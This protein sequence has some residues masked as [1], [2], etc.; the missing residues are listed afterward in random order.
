MGLGGSM[1]R[2]FLSHS[3]SDKYYVEYIAEKFGKDIAIYDEYSFESGLNTFSEILKGLDSSDIFVIFLSNASLES[4]WVKKELNISKDLL[5]EEKLKQIYPIIIDK[6]LTYN[7][8]RIPNWMRE[9]NN[10]YVLR[11]IGG[12]KIAYKK[13]KQ[14]LVLLNND[15]NKNYSIYVGHEDLTKK[16]DDRYYVSTTSIK[17]IIACGIEGIGRQSFINHCIKVPKTFNDSYKPIVID[18]NRT[19]SIDVIIS[20]LIESGLW[21]D[22]NLTINIINELSL[23]NKINLLVEI[24][25]EIQ[26]VKEFVIFR[27]SG[28]LIQRQEV[29]WW[30]AKSLE[31]IRNELTIGI[32]T[33]YN[34][35]KSK[36][37][38]DCYIERIDE[39]DETGKLKMLDKLSKINNINL[40]RDDIQFFQNIVTGHPLQILFCIENIKRSSLE[41]V[42]RNS[43]E[44][45]EFLSN[46]T[47]QIIDKYLALLDYKNE[48]KEKFLSY[49]TFLAGYS[50]IPIAEILEIN[51]LDKDYEVFYHDL[52]SFCI[53][54]RTGL[55]NDL[56][57]VSP[58]VVDYIERSGI[59]KPED[60]TKYLQKEYELFK[61]RL[62]ENNLDEYCYSQIE[63]NIKEAIIKEDYSSDYKLI[64]PSII[65][66]AVIKLYDGKSY[67]KVKNVCS[68]CMASI[69]L[70]DP[71][72]RQTLYFYYAMAVARKKENIIFD[73]LD[74]KVYGDYIL[75]E[76]QIDFIKGFYYKLIGRYE[77]AVKHFRWCLEKEHNYARARRELVETYVLLDEFNLALDLARLN[78]NRF[79][80]NI[81]NIYQYFNC[82]I[83]ERIINKEL[84]VE[85]LNKAKYVDRILTNSKQFYVEMQA[86]YKQI[87]EGDCREAINIMQENKKVFDNEVLYYRYLFDLY[88]EIRDIDKMGKTI[89]ILKSLIKDD[90]TYLP[91]LFRRECIYIY[92]KNKDLA[93]V[94]NKIISVKNISAKTLEK[95]KDYVKAIK[96]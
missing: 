87:I 48:K 27:D 25:K 23:E 74:G 68:N 44:I 13:I 90:S 20:K 12:R 26:Q 54:R 86:L 71:V 70:W 56:L 5:D 75:E 81:F 30:L 29:V 83:R 38:K 50:N 79:P 46:S 92:V 10:S 32:V 42:K 96:L 47:I 64:Y 93:F 91:L 17:C 78:Y 11:Y 31:P 21:D 88:F 43:Y 1:N 57:S 73:V 28:A 36:T 19:D 65:L 61:T 8:P 63:Q 58:S 7:D 76:F 22:D 6:N 34:V 14:Q 62:K 37:S 4:D 89:N 41:E 77:D 59:K 24:F 66:K 53:V 39:L 95:I 52:L 69:E 67:D 2:V 40:D 84:I 33:C 9:G 35:R 55:N 72:I 45:K 15:N 18:V 16:F 94:V 49:L 3:S 82:L 85:L 51:E 80:D 60:I